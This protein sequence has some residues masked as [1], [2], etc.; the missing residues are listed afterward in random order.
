MLN[1]RQNL[2]KS[3][4]KR[5]LPL[6][7][8]RT[9]CKIISQYMFTF[10]VIVVLIINSKENKW[11]YIN[12]H[13]V[14]VLQNIWKAHIVLLFDSRKTVKKI[15]LNLLQKF[16]SCV[17]KLNKNLWNHSTLENKYFSKYNLELASFSS[18]LNVAI[19]WQYYLASTLSI[20]ILINRNPQS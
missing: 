17:S 7:R 10:L 3:Y 1:V 12:V 14:A 11:Q 9:Y 13:R 8:Q 2:L 15:L 4:L 5:H 6:K 19:S 16:I 18:T 20:S